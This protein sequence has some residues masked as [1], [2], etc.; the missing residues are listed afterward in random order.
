[1]LEMSVR[2]GR[3]HKPLL[4][5]WTALIDTGAYASVVRTGLIP[6]NLISPARNPLAFH[7]ANGTELTGGDSGSHV[8]VGL[9]HQRNGRSPVTTTWCNHFFYE[10]AISHDAIFG[11]D[12]LTTHRVAVVP[13]LH[14]LRLDSDSI[15]GTFHVGM[16]SIQRQDLPDD[17]LARGL[18]GTEPEIPKA[19]KTSS[20]PILR[21]WFDKI[22]EWSGLEPEVDA[23]SS[24]ANKR[25][26]RHS[27]KN[28]SAFSQK[29][30]K[31]CLWA[32]PPF[33][34]IDDCVAKAIDDNVRMILVV[35]VWTAASWWKP[36]ENITLRHWDL[37]NDK[38]V[39]QNEKG[40]ELPPREWTT[41][42]CVIDM[43]LWTSSDVKRVKFN[44]IFGIS[45]AARDT[46]PRVP[47]ATFDTDN[48]SE[49]EVSECIRR[50]KKDFPSLWEE[51]GDTSQYNRP[52]WAF[53]YV[54]L[55]PDAQAYRARA[56]CLPADRREATLQL[57]KKWEGLGWITKCHGTSD[58]CS[59]VV[60][61]PHQDKTKPVKEW[62]L[63]IDYRRLN[64]ATV[65]DSHPLPLIEHQ[66]NKRSRP[67]PTFQ[68]F[69][70][71][72]QLFTKLLWIRILSS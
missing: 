54:K 17:P 30:D 7:T 55:R 16:H 50:C 59:G 13:W 51:A 19:W 31:L 27:D 36:L 58:W 39:F 41:R 56:F 60:P 69:G 52:D 67:R 53:G 24:N 46:A 22:V 61:K 42:A 62:R 21:S 34:L 43:E 68:F 33:H 37:P 14:E 49:K 71:N 9:R 35:P 47:I 10:A 57:C 26:E 2:I 63:V 40:E 72:A 45:A 11:Y 32:N 65:D 66:I 20:Y 18:T 4:Q 38:P 29:W 8:R 6:S 70:F 15:L 5:R 12:F 28:I 1:M 3:G 48:S 25:C 23:F 64:D 44:L